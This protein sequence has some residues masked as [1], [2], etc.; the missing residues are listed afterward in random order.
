MMI[1]FDKKNKKINIRTPLNFGRPA[2]NSKRKEKSGR[3]RKKS[4]LEPNRRVAVYI[5]LTSRKITSRHFQCYY[6][7]QRLVT[8]DALLAIRRQQR[9]PIFWCAQLF[10]LLVYSIPIVVLVSILV[11]QNLIVLNKPIFFYFAKPSTRNFS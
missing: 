4:P 6:E 10:V 8:S 11:P 5:C 3:R 2:Q 7:R 9:L 1:K